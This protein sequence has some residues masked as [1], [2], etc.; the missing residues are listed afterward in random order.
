VNPISCR[1][2]YAQIAVIDPGQPVFHVKSLERL[3]DDSLILPTTSA[4]MMSLFSVL[5][6]MLAAVGIYGV[7]AYA[8]GQQTREIGVRIALG[9]RPG[10]VAT[11][12]LRSGLAPVIFGVLLGV[13]GA[14]GASSLIANALYGVM[15]MDRPTYVIAGVVLIAIGALACAVPA[16]RASRV[17]PMQ[18]LRID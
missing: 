1:R 4:A 8:V 15:P 12:V 13:A 14:V 17:E 16:W 7:V 9:A 11:L 5:T 3:V 2:Q 10:D 6:V 18:A